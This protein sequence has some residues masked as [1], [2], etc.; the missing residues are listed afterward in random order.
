MTD[1][2]VQPSLSRHRAMVR[3]AR[4]LFVTIV[5]CFV[6]GTWRHPLALRVVPSLVVLYIV[7][8]AQLQS[9]G[10]PRSKK[11]QSAPAKVSDRS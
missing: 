3:R 5:V 10:K 2:R 1:R 7:F 4:V 6:V 8:A 11:T 9:Q